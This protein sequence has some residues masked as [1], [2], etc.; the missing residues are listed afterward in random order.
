MHQQIG[1]SPKDTASNMRAILTA[2]AD[3]NIAGLAPS[4]DPP[5]IRVLVEDRDFDAAYDA[6]SA[7]GL[8]PTIHS[9]V[10]VPMSDKPGGLKSA[11]DRLARKGYVVESI[12]V[13]PGRPK[14][15]NGQPIEDQVH[16]SFGIR[17]TGIADWD[18][19][20]ADELGSEI[21]AGL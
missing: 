21:G 10:T 2:L 16:V 12:L 3:V 4:F 8:D 15:S 14:D 9:A 17:Q 11:M 6:M 20:R 13:L 5:H 1:G 7:A 19:D 18:D